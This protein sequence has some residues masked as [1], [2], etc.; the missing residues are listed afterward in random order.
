MEIVM[1][2][3]RMRR[4]MQTYE[5]FLEIPSIQDV[6][7]SPDGSSV[8]YCLTPRT[9]ASLSEPAVADIWI[10][11]LSGDSRPVVSGSGDHRMPCWSPDGRMLAFA[12]DRAA[13]GILMPHLIGVEGGDIRRIGRVAG[14]TEQLQWSR[15]GQ[16]L[17]V[18]TADPGAGRS[19]DAATV[20]IPGSEDH[21]TDALVSRPRSAWRRLWSISLASETARR[22]SPEGLNVW[23]FDTHGAGIV[24]A[25]TSEDPSENAWFSSAISVLDLSTGVADVIYQ[26][27]WQLS[28]VRL[29][30]DERRVAFVEGLNSVRG[31][32][33]GTI[34]VVDRGG[35]VVR[36]PVESDVTW[37]DWR[38]HQ[39]LW[40]AALD[41]LGSCIGWVSID[42]EVHRIWRGDAQVGGPWLP[43]FSPDPQRRFV[44]AE[45]SG[46]TMPP[47]L[48]VLSLDGR[49]TGWH[50]I[51][52]LSAGPVA[53]MEAVHA[54]GLTWTS[55]DGQEVDG[56]LVRSPGAPPGPLPL[57]VQAHGGPIATASMT[58]APGHGAPSALVAA[59][60]AVFI[61][62]Y[63][64]SPGRGPD[65]IHALRF[66][67]G[68]KDLADICTGI[69]F[70]IASGVAD[71]ERVGIIGGSYGGY[72]AA[73]LPIRTGR[74]KAAVASACV[75]NWLSSHFATNAPAEDSPFFDP[76]DLVGSR[77][78][79]SPVMFADRSR[80]PILLIHGERD[81]ASPVGQSVE[82]YNV[83]ARAGCPVEL[84]IYPREPH[85]LVEHAHV[86]DKLRRT[87]GWLDTH[88][89]RETHDEVA[90][91]KS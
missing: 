3:D 35:P 42:G 19:Q 53:R 21:G 78:D 34:T 29:A 48:R 67:Y 60:Y 77:L 85:M 4:A 74:F 1:T 69:D 90:G 88:L 13:A 16:Q 50:A 79:R 89:A 84:V 7:L 58:F 63:R 43:C 33:V 12:S 37:I 24:A 71:P 47:E 31:G 30:P 55:S 91:R 15:D 66:N 75:S 62:N 18:L 59:G 6:R 86:M 61:P 46:P 39:T 23:S 83:L 54:E 9:Y 81:P 44:V 28:H 73:W 17:F 25:I 57:V 11:E 14:S 52:G 26:P 10:T 82:L 36:L 22:L 5:A 64:G 65:F 40:F 80:T 49:D 8:T 87:V 38:D 70:L 20:T 56:I 76:E 41:R 2:D 68:V 27:K 51:T 45:V 32:S 72:L